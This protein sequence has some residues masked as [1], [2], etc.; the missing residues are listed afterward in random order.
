M[1]G[2]SG[3]PC[4]QNIGAHWC[5]G[6]GINYSPITQLEQGM[7]SYMVILQLGHVT[8]C[9]STFGPC[10]RRGGDIFLWTGHVGRNW[11]ERNEKRLKTG[12]EIAEGECCSIWRGRGVK[13]LFIPVL[14]H[15]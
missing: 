7:M 11:T 12:Y 8:Y 1:N 9:S 3:I 14:A 6:W 13:R 10:L 4:E 15:L 2:V 5:D